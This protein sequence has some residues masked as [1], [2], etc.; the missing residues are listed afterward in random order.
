MTLN[1]EEDYP[2]GSWLGQPDNTSLRVR[3]PLTTGNTFFMVN[4]VFSALFFVTF[5]VPN[6]QILF[7]ETID[8]QES[9]DFKCKRLD[10]FARVIAKRPQ[11][12][13]HQKCCLSADQLMRLEQLHPGPEK[14]ALALLDHLFPRQRYMISVLTRPIPIL[15]SPAQNIFQGGKNGKNK[16]EVFHFSRELGGDP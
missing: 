13:I 3:V 2:Y 1:S 15:P 16:K 6:I 11:E 14:M 4:C 7:K 12:K 9:V 5:P 8:G 10:K